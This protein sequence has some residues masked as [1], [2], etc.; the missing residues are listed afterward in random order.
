MKNKN[1]CKSGFT[2]I[3]LLVV[4]LIIGILAGIALP[5]YKKAVAKARVAKIL[6]KIGE[7]QRAA[8]IALLE[9]PS[10]PGGVG[11]FYFTG[12]LPADGNGHGS[13]PY[14]GAAVNPAAGMTPLTGTSSVD[15]DKNR[16]DAY[17]QPGG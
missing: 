13:S 7:F 4:V 9:P 12:S 14:E 5:Q 8:D 15:N 1:S 16:W 17:I 3:E 2:L 11:S 10:A 6:H